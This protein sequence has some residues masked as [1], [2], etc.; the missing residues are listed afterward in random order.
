[1]QQL[2]SF[3]LRGV[4]RHCL[5][6]NVIL[7]DETVALNKLSL[8]QLLGR[9]TWTFEF[10]VTGGERYQG[11]AYTKHHRLVRITLPPHRFAA[12]NP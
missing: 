3:V 9:R 1:M 12:E 6:A 8:A 5:Q 4:Q 11:H 7:L 10:T 2:K